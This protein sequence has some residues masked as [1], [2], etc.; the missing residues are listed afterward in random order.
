MATA[1]R[2]TGLDHLQLAMPAGREEDADAFDRD[3][4]GFDVVPKPPPDSALAHGNR[5]ELI[6]G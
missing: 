1:V 3:L 6:A 2:I 5:I 4:L